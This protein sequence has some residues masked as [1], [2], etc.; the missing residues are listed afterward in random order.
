MLWASTDEAQWRAQLDRYSQV[1]QNLAAAT[2]RERLVELDRW[3]HEELPQIIAQRAPPYVTKDELVKL[4]QWKVGNRAKQRPNLVKFVQEAEP[5][6]VHDATLAA[7][8]AL[9][10]GQ[11][12]G[13][14]A[15]VAAL[16]EAISALADPKSDKK[17]KGLGPATASALMEAADSSVGWMSDEAMRAVLGELKYT[18]DH[19][20]R[21]V[22]ALRAKAAA[23]TAAGGAGGR[24]WSAKEVEQCLF[25]EAAEAEVAAKAAGGGGKGGGSGGKAAS[26]GKR[27]R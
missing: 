1:V 6:A 14:P 12:D 19:G 13:G 11:R 10:R 15:S 16:R 21:L 4:V 9:G 26:S 22:E 8:A 20:I 27:K 18:L 17:I 3:Y 24:R 23:L 2:G 25:A 7:L 5:A